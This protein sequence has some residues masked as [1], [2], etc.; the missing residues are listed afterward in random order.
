MNDYDQWIKKYFGALVR[1]QT[2][3][4][5]LYLLLSF[6]LGIFY[7][8]FLVTG[9]SL[10]FP[11]II[12][13]VGI[14][15][16]AAVFAASWGLCAFERGMAISM[17]HVT[18]PPM[19]RPAPATAGFWQRIREYLT[20][21]VTWKGLLFL[22]CRF[23]LGIINFTLVVA[24]LATILGLVAAPFIYSWATFDL[25]FMVV[26]SLSDALLVMILGL[27]VAPAGL[28]LL[29]FL[30]RIQGEFARVML[31]QASFA[32]N[33]PTAPVVSSTPDQPATPDNGL[34]Q[35]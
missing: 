30:A 32:E 5:L 20:N 3:L 27:A 25:G 1:P 29:N 16:L 14:L 26:D 33:S 15:I 2:Y 23:P 6:P 21:P 18:I 10:G 28:H 4:N 7:F 31:G 35:S 9:L 8:V 11:L 34:T 24:I 13:W 19:S 17:L 22:F 12:L